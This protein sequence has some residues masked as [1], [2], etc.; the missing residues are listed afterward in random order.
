MAS[1][2]RVV[3]AK[4]GG[5]TASVT[6]TANYTVNSTSPTA[7]TVT[8]TTLVV[9][10]QTVS[11]GTST[12]QATARSSLTLKLTYAVVLNFGGQRVAGKSGVNYSTTYTFSG[13]ASVAKGHSATTS[14]LVLSIDGTTTVNISVPVKTSYTVKYNANSGVSAP[15]NQTKWYG[16]D[17]TITTAKPSK[18]DYHCIGWV[19][20]VT[21]AGTGISDWVGGQVY[22]TNSNLDLYAVWERNYQKPTLGNLHIDRCQQNGTLDDDGGYAKAT[23]DWGVFRTTDPLYYG[24]ST[25]PYADNAVDTCTVTVGTQ[26][27]TATL[28][29]QSGTAS[30]IVGNGSYDADTIYT[31]SVSITDT[32]TIENDN[33]TTITGELSQAKFPIDINSTA[34]AI[35]FLSTAPDDDEGVFCPDMTAQEVQDF[36]DNLAGGGGSGTA[37][38]VVEQ[39]TSGI[40]TYR[41]WNSGIAECWGYTAVPSATYSANGGYKQV[42]EAVPSIFNTTPITVHASGYITTL[43]QTSIGY[44]AVD[45]SWIQTYLIN[46]SASA[47]TNSGR[48]YWE[49]KGTWK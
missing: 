32:Q 10:A 35:A 49:L 24:G 18:T 4:S 2:S 27:A 25:T 23:F 37:D 44:T 45:S 11:G 19:T 41:K 38:R 8:S 3:T 21:R 5:A 48:V 47:V 30:V 22:S 34:T 39:G 46:R 9:G 15:S 42:A 20:D 17:L 28:T 29:G 40:W 6:I 12:E 33:T 36:V 26:S 13:S 31:A 7:T 16:E 43:V 1:I 14:P